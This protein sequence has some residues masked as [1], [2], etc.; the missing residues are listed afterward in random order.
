[1]YVLTYEPVI[2]DRF[3]E[4]FHF[5]ISVEYVIIPV[6]APMNVIKPVLFE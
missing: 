2:L 6:V 4:F 5:H 1:M 3:G